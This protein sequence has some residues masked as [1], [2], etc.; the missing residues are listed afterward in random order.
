M[1]QVW[2]EPD[3]AMTSRPVAVA[4]GDQVAGHQDPAAVIPVGGMPRD[5]CQGHGRQEGGQADQAK[6]ERVAGEVVDQ[7]PDRHVL[8]LDGQSRQETGGQ[9]EAEIPAL[10]DRRCR[11][12]AHR[13]SRSSPSR[14]PTGSAK[15]KPAPLMR[16]LETPFGPLTTPSQ[17]T[18]SRPFTLGDPG[19]EVFLVVG[20][21][22]EQ[23]EEPRQLLVDGEG[24]GADDVVP[25][26]E[27]GVGLA[28]EGNLLAGNVAQLVAMFPARTVNRAG[29]EVA[30]AQSVSAECRQLLFRLDEDLGSG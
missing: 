3:T 22:V 28:V 9:V 29:P 17:V 8:H 24:D 11:Q 26:N 23:V 20:N 15:V 7:P 30:H 2:L 21:V 27:H 16:A 5:Q 4:E 10:E 1:S 6:G 12:Q 13:A 14:A 18:G 19:E 25:M